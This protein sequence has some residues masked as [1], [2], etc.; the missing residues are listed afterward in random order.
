MTATEKT[1][2]ITSLYAAAAVR[3]AGGQYVGA[4]ATGSG[5]VVFIFADPE[6]AIA[7][8]ERRYYRHD[9]PQVQPAEYV[10]QFMRLRDDIRAFRDR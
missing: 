10:T 5:R 3:A 6:D 4:E 8:L 2:G 1:Y 9:F 7:H